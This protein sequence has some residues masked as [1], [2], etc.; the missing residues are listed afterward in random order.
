LIKVFIDQSFDRFL[1]DRA[2]VE[3]NQACE[4]FGAEVQSASAS[5]SLPLAQGTDSSAQNP[6]SSAT[7]RK[8]SEAFAQDLYSCE[9]DSDLFGNEAK[10]EQNK[11]I[12]IAKGAV[13]SARF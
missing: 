3:F 13:D 2:K 10:A 1:C 9:N 6:S 8:A 12:K 5:H 7:K 11:R 4:A